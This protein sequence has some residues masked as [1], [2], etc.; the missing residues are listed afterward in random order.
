M[1]LIYFLI[2]ALVVFL[3][4]YLIMSLLPIPAKGKT[5]IY[6]ILLLIFLLWVL[7]RSPSLRI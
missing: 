3:I 5:I 7:Q 2:I 4:I 1:S 6:V